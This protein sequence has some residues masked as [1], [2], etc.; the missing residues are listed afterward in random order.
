[1]AALVA[2]FAINY[3]HRKCLF[4]STPFVGIMLNPASIQV[5]LILSA[6]AASQHSRSSPRL[7][8]KR[9]EKSNHFKFSLPPVIP[10]GSSTNLRTPSTRDLSFLSAGRRLRDGSS[11]MLLKLRMF[12]QWS[13]LM[14]LAAVEPDQQ[15]TC[16]VGLVYLSYFAT[17]HTQLHFSTELMR[18]GQTL[19]AERP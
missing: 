15:V 19:E 17:S 3:I 10:H 14:W 13:N 4:K 6:S 18:A 5:S 16:L 2:N 12:S 1:M 9:L 8:P 7:Q 11:I